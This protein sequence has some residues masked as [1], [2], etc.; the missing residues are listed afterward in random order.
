[1]ADYKK[2]I[3]ALETIGDH[4]PPRNREK[5]KTEGGVAWVKCHQVRL[6]GFFAQGHRL[7]LT[8]GEI[9]KKDDADPH[10]IREAGRLKSLFED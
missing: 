1:M 7:M 10:L 6:Y 8:G 9:K 3:I 5:F 4:G 2:A